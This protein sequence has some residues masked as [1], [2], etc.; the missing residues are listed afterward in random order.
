VTGPK[1][2]GEWGVEFPNDAGR[3]R[4]L[5]GRE[6]DTLSTSLWLLQSDDVSFCNIP[7]VYPRVP[8]GDNIL[9]VLGVLEK[10]PEQFK[11]RSIKVLWLFNRMHHR[12][13]SVGW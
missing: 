11:G 8:A 6:Q 10:H 2:P 12:L 13:S 4:E 3:Q 7:D 1:F 5:T 9:V